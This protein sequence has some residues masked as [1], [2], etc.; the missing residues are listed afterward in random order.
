MT[1]NRSE[2]VV[3]SALTIGVSLC[4]SLDKVSAIRLMFNTPQPCYLLPPP[5]SRSI[6]ISLSLCAC[7]SCLHPLFLWP[8][9]RVHYSFSLHYSL[10]MG[11]HHHWRPHMSVSVPS[12]PPYHCEKTPSAAQQARWSHVACA[13]A[14]YLVDGTISVLSQEPQSCYQ[15]K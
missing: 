6:S 10:K 11:C 1:W 13:C 2:P 4:H 9:C 8:V 15:W 3:E 5:P 7:A 14:S 12:L